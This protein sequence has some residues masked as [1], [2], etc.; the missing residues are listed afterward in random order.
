MER[1]LLLQALARGYCSATN[2]HKVLD[3]DLIIAMADEVMKIE[4][5]AEGQIKASEIVDSSEPAPSAPDTAQAAPKADAV[6]EHVDLSAQ[7][8]PATPAAAV[9]D[10]A[11]DARRLERLVR[12]W[13]ELL[14]IICAADKV[15]S[16]TTKTIASEA[17]D[18][19]EG[20]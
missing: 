2:S 7:A 11:R 10:E 3:S 16:R 19:L 12:R 13:R 20:K 8:G 18:A 17:A 9:P 1:D 5:N 6:S 4:N 15:D 14:L